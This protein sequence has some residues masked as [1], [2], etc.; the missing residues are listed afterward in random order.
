LKTTLSEHEQLLNSTS[1]VTQ[2]GYSMSYTLNC[3]NINKTNQST[4]QKNTNKQANPSLVGLFQ[5][6][7]LFY[8]RFTRGPRPHEPVTIPHTCDEKSASPYS[9]VWWLCH[10]NNTV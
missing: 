9:T 6:M 2:I 3:R 7:R 8:P 5:H 4:T 1:P 10:N